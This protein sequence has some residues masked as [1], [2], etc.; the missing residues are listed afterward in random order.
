MLKCYGSEERALAAV[1]AN[2]QVINPS[3]SFPNTMI[4]SKRVLRAA[5]SEAE[6]LEVMRLNP[7]VLQCGPSLEVLGAAEIKAV[8]TARSLGTRLLPPSLRVPALALVLAALG[9]VLSQSQNADAAA[10][11]DALKPLLGAGLAS[12]FAFVLYG[13]ANAGR[14][15]KRAEEK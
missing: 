14:S 3:Y 6:A 5:M 4:E 10:A 15:A 11:V 13:A 8:A 1:Q 7:A 9:Y 12:I 2:P